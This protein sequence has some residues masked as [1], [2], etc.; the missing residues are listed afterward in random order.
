[1]PWLTQDEQGKT[2]SARVAFWATLIFTLV[3]IAADSV[4]TAVVVP[5]P[6]YALLAGLLIALAAWAGGPRA[7]QYLGPQVGRVASAV[8]RARRTYPPPSEALEADP[9]AE[10]HEWADGDPHRGL[11]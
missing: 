6:A 10:P 9:D 8:A 7:L 5:E 2:S 11:L 3:L 1:M 4:T